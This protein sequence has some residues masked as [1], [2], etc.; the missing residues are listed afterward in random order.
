MLAAR[1]GPQPPA[2]LLRTNVAQRFI[3]RASDF[4][5]SAD[6]E[7]GQRDQVLDL[8]TIPGQSPGDYRTLKP[9]ARTEGL[10]ASLGKPELGWIH[11]QLQ[12]GQWQGAEVLIQHP[13][14]V[15]KAG[16]SITDQSIETGAIAG[17]CGFDQRINGRSDS[18]GPR[19]GWR[20]RCSRKR[21]R[22]RLPPGGRASRE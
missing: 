13:G 4:D 1:Q 19:G 14:T 10:P 22:G 21:L 11:T 8:G 17:A 5:L 18:V 6:L 16:V 7:E 3:D 20:H 9:R 2:W 12:P 15:G